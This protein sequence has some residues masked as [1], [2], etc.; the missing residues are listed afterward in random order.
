MEQSIEHPHSAT[1]ESITDALGVDPH[2]GW[3][4]QQAAKRLAA[5][6]PNELPAPPAV[7]FWRRLLAQLRG[8]IVIILLAAVG[9]SIVL[10]DWI[11]AGAILAIV[12]LNALVGAVQEARADTALKSLQAMAAPEATV[13]RDGR[14][15]RIPAREVVP[16]DVVV[17][18]TGAI[19][20]ADLR[21]IESSRLRIDES[22]LTGE[23][24]PSEKRADAVLDR[25]L[26]VGDRT[27]SA[28]SGTTVSYGRGRGL[29]VATGLESEIGR[30]ASGLEHTENEPTPLQRKLDEFG[31]LM[32]VAV[33]A[34][35]ALV[36][37][38]G[39]LRSPEAHVLFRDGLASYLDAARS[40]IAGLFVVA[41]SLAVAAVPEGLPAVVTMGLALGTRE[42]LR[43]NALVRRLP[44]V[45]T[46]GSTTVICTDKTGTLTRNRMTVR[47]VRTV[48]AE[49]EIVAPEGDVRCD[50]RPSALNDCRTL[51]LALVA[52]LL[53]NDA[54]AN[55]ETESGFI[56]DPTEGALILAAAAAGLD[57]RDAYPD[58]VAEVP[59]DSERK[60]MSTVHRAEEPI[61]AVDGAP[62]YVGFVKGAP[63]G[64][65]AL[66][67]ACE[68]DDG[69]VEM[70]ESARETILEANRE[71]GERGLRLL[72]V[73]YR[74]LAE[75]GE[76][77]TASDVESEL[78][79]LGL[80][81]L[82]D[83]PRPEVA[84]AV[85]TARRAGLRSVMITG[86]HATTG[87]AI[88]EQIGILRPEGRVLSGAELDSL[89]DDE[90]R[91]EVGE[92][93]V[94][95]RVSPQHK[96]RI[97][98]AL[99]GNGEVV[100]MTGD[101]VNDAP[102]LKQADVGI[103]MGIT[104][105]DVARQ[106]ADIV[107]TDDN[108][109]TIIAAV[110]QGRVIY[111]NIR[112][113]VFYL[114]SCNFAEI[115]ILFVA[116]LVGWPPPLAAIQLLWLNLVTDGA[117]ALALATE[118]GEPGIMDRPPRAAEE[119]IVDVKMARGIAVHAGALST[120][121]LAA[122]AVALH[123]SGAEVAGTVAFA[124][125]TLAELLR[126]YTARSE[127]VTLRRIGPFSNRWMQWAVAT[128]LV[129]VLAVLYV[130]FLRPL[131]D[132]DALGA[133]A[134][135]VIVPLAIVPALWI[136]IRK[137][138]RSMRAARRAAGRTAG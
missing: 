38:V 60:R 130:P 6:G 90:L 34:V 23:S 84:D 31:K 131:F 96:V 80:V 117:P 107:L 72:A 55:D 125:L 99:K 86:D 75:A 29:V 135:G 116:T 33:L 4:R 30:I 28:F 100:A 111:A 54:E 56:G 126:A 82:H 2:V 73:A 49:Y 122:F 127:E 70:T 3:T 110:E 41:V 76:E 11:E 89:S 36:F 71:M 98:E 57:R 83:P 1:I 13:L 115:A 44:S 123:G 120:A 65:V 61:P 26:L 136:E 77:P 88:A 138:W 16:G 104:G 94:F 81:A 18:E 58:R 128:S 19:V 42:M 53:C 12:L 51:H 40:T 24:V 87:R 92:I 14:S 62:A 68:T 112:K 10:G 93:D 119:R 67:T 66:C 69:P 35:C 52:G 20:P 103:A 79:F 109:A 105:T 59:F 97:V 9:V 21:L 101:G 8:V 91:R 78:T 137:G 46:L 106:T 25:S 17:L 37:V 133:A 118:R 113:T 102:A 7:P 129:F 63:D 124:T 47:S 132:V 45:E 85:E 95:A 74:G 43:R 27:N 50:G 134:W 15:E 39:L 32:G 48:H 64:I 22:S 5:A 121:V 114:L 108:Y